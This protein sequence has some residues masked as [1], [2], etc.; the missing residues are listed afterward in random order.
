M[1]NDN[2]NVSFGNV[3]CSVYTRR[4]AF[5]DDSHRKRMDMLAYT[6]LEFNYMEFPAKHFVV[7][8]RQNQFFEV[9]IFNN[10]PVPRI[11]IAMNN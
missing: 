10:A 5:N 11:A 4:I 1:I 9:N 3:D 7:F 2:P 8:A 6:L